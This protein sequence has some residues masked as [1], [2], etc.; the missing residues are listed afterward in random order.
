MTICTFAGHRIILTPD[1]NQRI[2]TALIN[3]LKS[4][5][6]FIFLSGGMGEFDTKCESAVN[7]MK[8]QNSSLSIS[9]K[10]ILPYMTNQINTEKDYYESKYDDILFPIELAQIHYKAA[11]K[12]RNQWMTEQADFILACVCRNHGGAYDMLNY[13]RHIGKPFLNLAEE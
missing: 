12:K 4:D 9:L 2:D 3:L 6:Q 1:I 13:A 10:L 8:R 7:R 11:I 5:N